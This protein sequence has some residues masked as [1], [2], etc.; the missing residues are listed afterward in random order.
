MVSDVLYQDSGLIIDHTGLTIRRYYFP[1]GGSKRIAFTDIDSV[2][3]RAMGWFTGRGRVWGSACPTVW[4]PL[5]LNRVRKRTLIMIDRGCRVRP[6]I[7]PDDP[8]RVVDLIRS[9]CHV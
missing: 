4:L 3:V 9:H 7:T 2:D 6:A 8:F 1:W 5:D